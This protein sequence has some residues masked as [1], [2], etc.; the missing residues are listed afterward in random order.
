M[1]PEPRNMPMATRM[2]TRNGMIFTA[3]LESFFRPFDED[4]VDLDLP[5]QACERDE[6]RA[7]RESPRA[8]S[9]ERGADHE[10]ASAGASGA[11]G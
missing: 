8:R 10:R 3:D 4:V 2:P 11:C 6:R 7:A 9:L 1:A 5:D